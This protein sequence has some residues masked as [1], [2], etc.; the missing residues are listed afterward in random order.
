M[1][2][3]AQLGAPSA[4]EANTPT[5]A[6]GELLGPNSGGSKATRGIQIKCAAHSKYL[7]QVELDG[8]V[9]VKTGNTRT[10]LRVLEVLQ[11]AARTSLNL[12]LNMDFCAFFIRS[13]RLVLTAI[14]DPGQRS[15]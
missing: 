3:Q 10:A 6:A 5:A 11:T 1:D 2:Q 7:V 8:L 12:V 4:R 15:G 9:A 13:T 14:P